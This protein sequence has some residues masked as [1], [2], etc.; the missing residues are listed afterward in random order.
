MLHYDCRCCVQVMKSELAR[1]KGTGPDIP[2]SFKH[3]IRSLLVFMF[4]CLKY[5]AKMCL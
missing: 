1:G 2:C 4:T 5:T 3:I